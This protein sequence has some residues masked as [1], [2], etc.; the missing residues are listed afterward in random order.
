LIFHLS[1]NVGD[2]RRRILAGVVVV[3]SLE[4]LGAAETLGAAERLGEPL[5][6]A[7]R[8]T[9]GAAVGIEL[10]SSHMDGPQLIVAI[11][12]ATNVCA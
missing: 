8:E 11:W 1:A 5:A 4:P 12:R 9:V 2:W 6:E 7:L 10:E 3:Q